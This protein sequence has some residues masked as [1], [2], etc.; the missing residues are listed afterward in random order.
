M[1]NTNW[2]DDMGILDFDSGIVD[3]PKDVK[4]S[5]GDVLDMLSSMGIISGETPKKST[6]KKAVKVVKDITI[7]NPEE[8]DKAV[9]EAIKVYDTAEGLV[10][11]DSDCTHYWQIPSEGSWQIGVCRD[12]NGEHWFCNNWAVLQEYSD[13]KSGFNNSPFP[14]TN[15]DA[16]A[17]REAIKD[18]EALDGELLDTNLGGAVA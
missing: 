7:V 10:I 17:E 15:P 16:L 12:C 6:N 14:L 5:A 2:W 8:L 3:K 18:I 9:V 1:S 4:A 11:P 13:T